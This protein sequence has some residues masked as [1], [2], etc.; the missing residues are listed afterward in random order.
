MSPL[1][2]PVAT[3]TAALMHHDGGS[4]VRGVPRTRW[5][6]TVSWLLMGKRDAG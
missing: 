1:E 3:V 5:S 4:G 2:D 6:L